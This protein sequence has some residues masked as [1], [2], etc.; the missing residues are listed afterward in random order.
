MAEKRRIEV[1]QAPP[2]PPE[3]EA[4]EKY[5][6]IGWG[7][8]FRQVY[9]RYWYVLLCMFGTSMFFLS[10]RGAVGDLAA[11]AL[12]VALVAGEI[13]VYWRVWGQK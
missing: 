10:V 12:T 2:P 9:A 5:K 11:T 3:P 13:Y 1:E 6:D 4:P 8:W 7:Q